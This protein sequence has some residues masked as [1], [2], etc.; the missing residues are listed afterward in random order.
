MA[1]NEEVAPANILILVDISPPATKVVFAKTHPDTTK[2]LFIH[3]LL[4]INTVSVT[5]RSD[6]NR[7]LDLTDKRSLPTM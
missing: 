2:S 4:Y 3:A 1:P 5:L 6:P 7:T